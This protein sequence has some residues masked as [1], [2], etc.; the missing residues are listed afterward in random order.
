MKPKTLAAMI[1]NRLDFAAVQEV[2][3]KKGKLKDYC[4][5]LTG[6]ERQLIEAQH[7][8]LFTDNE[9]GTPQS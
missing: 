4:E 2:E 3:Q 9:K 1:M 7:P 8:E 6:N 5:S